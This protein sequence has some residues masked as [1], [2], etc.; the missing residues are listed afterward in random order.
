[1]ATMQ[2]ELLPGVNL[3]EEVRADYKELVATRRHLH[4]IPEIGLDLPKTVEYVESRLDELSISHERCLEHG[5]IGMIEGAAD[6]PTV[7]LRADMDAL[8]ITEENTHDYVSQ[9]PGKMHA[10]GHDTHMSMLLS[11]TKRIAGGGVDGGRLKL[12]FQ[13]GEE[14]H[15]GA[16]KMV[17]AGVLENPK[18]DLAYGQHIWADAPT[19]KILIQEGPVMAAVDTV[20]ITIHGKGTHAA[21]PHGGVDPIYCAAQ[22]ITALQSVVS[23]SIDP[24]EPGVVTIAQINA[25]TAHN[26]IPPSCEMVGTVR[27]F[28]EATHETM[29][30]RI[31]EI[32]NGIANALGC[33]AEINYV[34]EHSATVNDA[35]VARIVREEAIAIV[36]EENVINKQQTMGAEDMSDFLKHVPGAF[37]FIGANNE[38]KGACYP[39]HHPKFNIDEDAMAIGAELMYR[40]GK[41]LL[42]G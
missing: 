28:D 13:P 1:M 38:A 40:V 11:A 16:E 5:V 2:D 8:P 4:G 6:G 22:I 35:E 36:G 20:Y 9:H 10:C 33:E 18:V 29:E 30:R 12:C 3:P 17:A 39:H 32:I 26:I 24:L 23:R 42:A 37:A 15:H 19:G 27:V 21:Y 31:H 34:H 7:M 14:G 41:R 25:G